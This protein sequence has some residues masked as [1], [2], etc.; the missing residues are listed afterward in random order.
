MEDRGWA[1]TPPARAVRGVII[2]GVLDP[3]IRAYTKRS[4]RGLEHL[5]ALDGPIILVANHCS[6][7]DTPLLLRT[8]PRAWRRRTAVAAAADYFYRKRMLAGIV[9]LAFGTVPV[10]RK[11]LASGDSMAEL[12]ADGWSLVIFA[13]GTRSRDGR[14][15]QLRNGAAALAAEHGVPLVPIHVGGT[16]EAMPTGRSWMVRR[17]GGGRHPIT[18]SFGAPLQVASPADR[19]EAMEQVRL[20]MAGCGAETTPDPRLESRRDAALDPPVSSQS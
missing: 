11:G 4:V 17:K 14:V 18:V 13:E 3:I 7:V 9:S 1:R 10:K 2:C 19:F 12:L 8:L 6:H 5:Q 20:F 15:G 16:H